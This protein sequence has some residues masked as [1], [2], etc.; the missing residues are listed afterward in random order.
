MSQNSQDAKPTDPP[1]AVP[2]GTER[3]A[4]NSRS[5][6]AGKITAMEQAIQKLLERRP[7]MANI[8][9]YKDDP[10]SVPANWCWE[11]DDGIYVLRS[12]SPD[13]LMTVI[14]E[15]VDRIRFLEDELDKARGGGL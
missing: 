4:S 15:L 10:E 6:M 11:F 3:I 13:R 14:K 5:I 1:P 9:T 7:G 12:C 8:N 2:A